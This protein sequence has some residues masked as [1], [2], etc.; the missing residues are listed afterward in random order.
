LEESEASPHFC[1]AAGR[2]APS[3]KRWYLCALCLVQIFDVLSRRLV[4][5]TGPDGMGK[6]AVATAVAHYLAVRQRFTG[7]VYFVHL[8]VGPAP[9]RRVC[10]RLR[11]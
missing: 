7:G 4:S 11:F 5:I 3:P 1:F 2:A 10:T 8:Q 6:T 9:A